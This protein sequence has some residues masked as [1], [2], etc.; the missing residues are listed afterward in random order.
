M[1][2]VGR[3][4]GEEER[5]AARPMAMARMGDRRWATGVGV[6]MMVWLVGFWWRWA[7]AAWDGME[8]TDLTGKERERREDGGGFLLYRGSPRARASR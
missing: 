4:G 3:E 5:A 8:T 7:L 6:A 1:E 2:A